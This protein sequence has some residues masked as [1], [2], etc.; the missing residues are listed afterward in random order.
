MDVKKAFVI[1]IHIFGSHLQNCDCFS[2]AH[3]FGMSMG[4][5]GGGEMQ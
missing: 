3:I 5:G 1:N 2:L 4:G